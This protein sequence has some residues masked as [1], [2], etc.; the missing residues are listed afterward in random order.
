MRRAAA[1]LLF[2]SACAT[3][4]SRSAP[5]GSHTESGFPTAA[6]LK[7]VATAP[8][9]T[10]GDAAKYH[11]PE[12][13]TVPGPFPQDV[14]LRGYAGAQPWDQ[15]LTK[16]LTPS[17]GMSVA[18]VGMHCVAQAFAE[19]YLQHKAMPS[20]TVETFILGRCRATPANVQVNFLAGEV[21]ASVDDAQLFQQWQ[22]SLQKTVGKTD[23]SKLEAVGIGW[24]R[25]ADRA[26]V[27]VARGER[28]AF[29][30]PV[31][32]ED[33]AAI[34][35]GRLLLPHANM[36]VNISQG[37]Y[38]YAEC[39][40]NP[41]LRLPEF[42][43]RCPMAAGDTSAWVQIASFASGRV[44]GDTAAV[45]LVGASVE[46]PTTFVRPKLPGS[47]V[48]VTPATLSQVFLNS[49]NEVRT[50]AGLQPLALASAQSTE[51][52][53][54][55]PHFFN[56]Q[57]VT[58]DSDTAETV[59][60]GLRAGWQV[61]ELV[62][63]SHFSAGVSVGTKSLRY[64]LSSLLQMP[65]S[66]QTLLDPEVRE[67]ALGP[68]ID[69]TGPFI[70]VLVSTYALFAEQDPRTVADEVFASLNRRRA[71]FGTAPAQRI[72]RLGIGEDRATRQVA[73]GRD[74]EVAFN[75]LLTGASQV[76]GTG[77]GG[78]VFVLPNLDRVEWPPDLV[79]IK[80]LNLHLS[81]TWYQPPYEPW[82]RYVIFAVYPAGH[83]NAI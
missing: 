46:P 64:V 11:D 54:L 20:P 59:S 5:T 28:R 9:P 72:S 7:K 76:L 35:K 3:G 43:L 60:L 55:A 36:R 58:N 63:Y 47:E 6:T 31:R 53:S 21:P 37:A 25:D 27:M 41:K 74:P 50:Q 69:P 30:E 71:E 32:I 65:L 80:D 52:E 1:L 82:G 78:F 57:L 79:Q 4:G 22:D 56:A 33:G 62:R 14:A 13:W 73:D 70:G 40:E 34:V 2:T 42:E 39:T 66:R 61:P 19:F 12:Q 49:I 16:S 68:V 81:V 8:P 51:A 17:A 67:I 26:V 29:L 48:E 83:G 24:A 38:A 75:S 45:L 15:L 77:V 23:T 10:L 44:L 18:S